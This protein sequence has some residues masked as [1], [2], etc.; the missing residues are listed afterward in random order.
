MSFG[1][2]EISIISLSKEQLSRK[3]EKTLFSIRPVS[4]F[5]MLQRSP[6]RRIKL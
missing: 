6:E 4:K 2:E 1:D 5:E 3:G